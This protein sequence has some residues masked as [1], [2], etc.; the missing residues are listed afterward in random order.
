MKLWKDAQ[1]LVLYNLTTLLKF[2]FLFKLLTTFLFM[3]LFLNL[4]QLIMKITGYSYLTLENIFFFFT[5]PVT[6]LLIILLIVLLTIYTMF[7]ITAMV[8]IFDESYHENK[9][10]VFDVIKISLKKCKLMLQPKNIGLPFFVLF[11]IPLLDLG[12][13]TN[14]ISSISIPEFIS[15]YISS[16]SLLLTI[17]IIVWLFL[18]SLLIKWI[19]SFHYMIL[20][21]CDFNKAKKRSAKLM[22]GKVSKNILYW[23]FVQFLFYL[24]YITLLVL[25]ILFIIVLDKILRN[26]IM[27]ETFLVTVISIFIAILLMGS[28]IL[29]TPITYALVSS[30]FYK[31]KLENRERI[32]SPCFGGITK[33]KDMDY[34]LKWKLFILGSFG[35]LG[36]CILTYQFLSGKYNFNI[37]Y[38]R[39]MEITA[40][41]GAST[42]YPENTMSAFIGAKELGADWIELDVQQTKDGKIVV[43]HDSNLLRITGVNKNIIDMTYDEIKKLDAGSHFQK[44]YSYEKIPL[45]EEVVEYADDNYIRLNIEL[46]PTGSETNFE[47]NVLEILDKYHF[48][49]K[50][51]ITSQTYSVLEKI[52]EIDS[53]YK[54]VYVMS[55]AIGNITD[56]DKA[57]AFSVEAS[58][59][60]RKLV[61]KVHNE[62]K[63]IYSWTVNTEDSIHKM[64]YLNV[65]NIITDNITLGRETVLK[66]NHSNFINEFIE[67]AKN[68]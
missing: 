8:V 35:V 27:I 2:E 63:Q 55:I 23:L 29:A 33:N 21:K 53:T 14:V 30:L 11:L 68:R 59:I 9:I 44:K 7:D 58:N 3:P 37:E 41:R 16:N 10:G 32:F 22:K 64:I 26:F 65:D 42:I 52:K 51:V 48:R 56:L 12:V 19:Y 31:N 66:S 20:E 47:E 67:A 57:D 6:I 4:F 24:L 60:N 18:T 36:C 62:G 61:R 46:K 50:C 34:K 25:G 15:D 17:F 39:N 49:E 38:T 28:L 54:T 13:S 5:N 40:H 1:K 45:L 43:C